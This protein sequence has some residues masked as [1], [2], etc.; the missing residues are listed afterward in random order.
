MPRRKPAD[1]PETNEPNVENAIKQASQRK[2]PARRERSARRSGNWPK[3]LGILFVLF[4]VVLFILPNLI[5]WTPLKQMVID[6]GLKDLQGR[7][8]ESTHSIL[9]QPR[10]RDD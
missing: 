5:G 3:R 10:L 8:I 1:A 2:R 6:Y 9:D 4:L 7:V